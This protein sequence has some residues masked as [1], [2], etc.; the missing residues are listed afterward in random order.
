M[1][2]LP[3]RQPV[4]RFFSDE[5]KRAIA[6]ESDQPGVS[7]SQVARKHGIVTGMLFRWRVQFGVPQKKRV[8][9]A[10]VSLADGAPAILLL[11]DLVRPPD[12]MMAKDLSDGRR[13]FVPIGSD[14]DA[15]REHVENGG[16]AP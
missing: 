7:V 16:I 2:R 9:L 12:G 15:V 14:P 3:P 11:R 6:V 1:S 8:K 10:P 4:R 5:E 13:V